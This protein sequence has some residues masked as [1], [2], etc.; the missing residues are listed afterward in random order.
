MSATLYRLLSWMSPSYPIGAYTY[1]HGVEFAV[2]SG[3]VSGKENCRDWIADILRFGTGQSDAVLLAAAYNGVG[4]SEKLRMVAETAS[5]FVATKEFALE[6]QA[7]GKAF[8]EISAKTW[9]CQALEGF[10]N[11]WDG[12]IAY[13]VAVGV[14]AAGHK[15]PLAD[16]L[17]G[18]LHGIAANLVS[19]AVRL[20]PLGQTD[21]QLILAS[22]EEVVHSTAHACAEST[23]DDLASSALMVDWTSM[24]HETQYTRLFRS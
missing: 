21:G 19:A 1:S 20:V 4:N 15:I 8:V 23:L 14:V 3:L 17:N 22:L 11:I 16:T 5:V 9:N 13:P 10:Q 7:Q 18:Y 2:E 24:Q 12:P 6:S